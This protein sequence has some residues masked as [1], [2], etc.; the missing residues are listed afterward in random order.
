MKQ[1]SR[2]ICF[3][4]TRLTMGMQSLAQ[5]HHCSVQVTNPS[6][7]ARIATPIVIALTNAPFCTFDFVSAKVTSGDKEIA[8]QLDD[9]DGNGS[10]DELVFMTN[11][12]GNETQTFDIA[13]YDHE[14]QQAYTPEVDAY[15][16]LHDS[17]GK[18]PRV[19]AITYPGDAD[20]LD[21]YNSIYGH[22][23]V[24]ENKYMAYRIYMDIRNLPSTVLR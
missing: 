21:M 6:D 5:T 10:F 16:K 9:I 18:R 24:F 8:S 3:F 4:I 19:N 7:Q 2:T 1:S 23:A 20:L 17:K 11:L 14:Q 22:G 12:T 15:I 13:F